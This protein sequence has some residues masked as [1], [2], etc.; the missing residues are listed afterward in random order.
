M[1]RPVRRIAPPIR[2]LYDDQG[3]PSSPPPAF[4]R[5]RGRVVAWDLATGQNIIETSD[6]ITYEN[7]PCLNNLDYLFIGA[8]D[9]VELITYSGLW[10]VL[11]RITKP[12]TE[13]AARLLESITG[14]V[15]DVAT[16][17]GTSSSSYTDLSTPGPI[18]T[19][20]VPA[21]G[22]VWVRAR[23]LI[24]VTVN[25]G[26]ANGTISGLMSFEATGANV[27]SAS[28]DR[29]VVYGAGYTGSPS[30]GVVGAC[31]VSDDFLLQGLNPGVTTFTAKYRRATGASATGSSNFSD[32]VMTARGF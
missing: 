6:G 18:V 5:R 30:T 7:V 28:D 23:A 32:R 16:T 8:G 21:S 20:A 19:I 24:E 14:V 13:D 15:D 4:G 2:P 26:V 25:N 27:L 17:E 29:S 31:T 12:G 9:R 11:G 22:Q 1:T 10:Y 3:P